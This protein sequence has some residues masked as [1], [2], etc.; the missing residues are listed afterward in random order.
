[1][2]RSFKH[3]GLQVFFETGRAAGIQ[4]K[5]ANRLRLIL[6][7]LNVANVLE[8]VD[9]PGLYLHALKGDRRGS[10]A[11]KVSG[12]WRVTFQFTNGDVFL[13]NYEDYH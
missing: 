8:D 13:T 1:M 5:H 3:K 9:K 2:I 6:T 7:L 10:W 11:V 4:P 12:N